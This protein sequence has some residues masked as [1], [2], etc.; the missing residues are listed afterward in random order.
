MNLKS[1]LLGCAMAAGLA[2]GQASAAGLVN[3]GF[4]TGDFTGWSASFNTAVTTNH[5]GYLPTGGDFLGLLSGGNGQGVYAT[6][7][8]SFTVT[9][10]QT[11]SG[12]AAFLGHDYLPYDDDG[13]VSVFD[14]SSGTTLFSASIGTVGDFGSTPWTHFSTTLGTGSYTVQA[15]VR[16]NLDN[17]FS[18][19]LVIDSFSLTGGAAPEPAAWAMMLVGFGGMGALIRRRRTAVAA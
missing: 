16:N 5:D 7:S 11:L 10:T 15:G 19:H 3:G 1:A 12:D 14:N 4:E 6:V 2:A 9:G 17:N 18:S 13:F 8:Q